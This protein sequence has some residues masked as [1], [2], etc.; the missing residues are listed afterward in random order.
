MM[1]A[2]ITLASV[3]SGII[4]SVTGFGSAVFLMLIVPYFFNMVASSAISSSI[5]LGLS[6]TLAWKFR[7]QIQWRLCLL[8]T[9][10]YMVCSVAVISVIRGLDLRLLSIA[11]GVFLML[12]AVYFF[13]V[14]KRLSFQPN[15]KSACICSAISGVTSGLFGIGGPLMAAF[16]VLSSQDKKNYIANTQFLFAATGLVN[17]I[18]RI[19]RGIYTMDLIP[20]TLLGLAGI[21]LGKLIGLRILDR[22]NLDMMKKGVYAFVGISGLITVLQQL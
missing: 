2:I 9:A 17:L 14:A 21:T 22:L 3:V 10:I 11:F 20:V 7:S 1:Y 13:A 15:W 8:P 19:A 18:T 5:T 6:G 12:L 4:Q 16:F